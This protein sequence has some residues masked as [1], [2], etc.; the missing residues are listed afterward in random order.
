MRNIKVTSQIDIPDIDNNSRL[1]R[2][3]AGAR[4]ADIAGSI[5]S[6]NYN[7]EEEQL[8]GCDRIVKR[9]Y[10][11]DCY[12]EQIDFRKENV[13]NNYYFLEYYEY[14]TRPDA[15]DFDATVDGSKLT[16]DVYNKDNETFPQ[17]VDQRRTT[18]VYKLYQKNAQGSNELIS[19]REV[20]K[21]AISEDGMTKQ[22]IIEKITHPNNG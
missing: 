11:N 17:T 18:Q 1:M 14:D 2:L 22:R 16:L 5:K 15:P 8:L 7:F 10:E 6:G 4:L 3:P 20:I 12:R 13:T 19:T 21:T 9:W